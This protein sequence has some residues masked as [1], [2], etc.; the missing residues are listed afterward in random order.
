V[1]IA[2][3]HNSKAMETAQMSYKTTRCRKIIKIRAEIN[4]T[5]ILKK[6]YKEQMKQKVSY[7]KRLTR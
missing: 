6:L 4:E 1:F 5:E 2:V 7:L 3:I